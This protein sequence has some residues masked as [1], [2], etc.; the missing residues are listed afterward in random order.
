MNEIQRI[1]C[2][3]NMDNLVG[4]CEDFNKFDPPL[5]LRQ[6]SKGIYIFISPISIS[7]SCQF[8]LRKLLMIVNKRKKKQLS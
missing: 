3:K 6:K 8:I 5:T 7:Y 4:N 1:T 2:E